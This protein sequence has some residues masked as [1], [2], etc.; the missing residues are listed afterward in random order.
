[1]I[2][3]GGVGGLLRH[4]EHSPHFSGYGAVFRLWLVAVTP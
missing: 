3:Q 4:E 2:V 1:M